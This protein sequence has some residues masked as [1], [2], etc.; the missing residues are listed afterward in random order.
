MGLKVGVFVL[1]RG[2]VCIPDASDDSDADYY[3]VD[4]LAPPKPPPPPQSPKA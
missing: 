1:L 3:C 2:E 4:D